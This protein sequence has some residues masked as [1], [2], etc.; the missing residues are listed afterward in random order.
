MNLVGRKESVGIEIDGEEQIV[1]VIKTN[2][3]KLV[4]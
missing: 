3:K 1:N 2:N 4:N